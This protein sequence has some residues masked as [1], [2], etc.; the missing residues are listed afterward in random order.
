[1]SNMSKNALPMIAEEMI[2]QS[3]G[4]DNG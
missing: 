4:E 2:Y 1:M 3:V